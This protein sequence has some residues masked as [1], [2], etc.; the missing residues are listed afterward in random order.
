MSDDFFTDI[1]MKL[2]AIALIT[3][4]PEVSDPVDTVTLDVPLLIRLLEYAR[5]DAKTDMDLHHVAEQLIELSKSGTLSMDH[6][7]D[8]V[9]GAVS[10]AKKISKDE[11]PCWPGYK[12]VGTKKKGGKEVPNCVPGKKGE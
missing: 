4:N 12:M 11:D 7:N 8:I 2:D 1:K 6:Y 9:P 10:E 5:E 3:E